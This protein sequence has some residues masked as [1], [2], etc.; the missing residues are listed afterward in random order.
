MAFQNLPNKNVEGGTFSR[1]N[2]A[3]SI[4]KGLKGKI[5]ACECFYPKEV[6]R[7]SALSK[8]LQRKSKRVVK[9]TIA[10]NQAE[11]SRQTAGTGVEPVTHCEVTLNSL[12][13]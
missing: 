13:Q 2:L 12:L 1:S 10:L 5:G 6:T 9:K 4:S 3:L 7:A 8:T 11:L